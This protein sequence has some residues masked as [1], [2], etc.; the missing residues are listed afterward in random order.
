M[1][2]LKMVC[3]TLHSGQALSRSKILLF[4]TQS[5]SPNPTA[6]LVVGF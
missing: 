5:S 2:S 1:V 6:N 4:L 3:D